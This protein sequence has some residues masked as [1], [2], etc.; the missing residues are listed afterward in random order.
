ME[1]NRPQGVRQTSCTILACKQAMDEKFSKLP[2]GIA[3][4]QLLVFN[5]HDGL[6]ANAPV[7]FHGVMGDLLS[8]KRGT[9]A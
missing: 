2:A 1:V 3:G 5:A 9:F 8:P 4:G 6:M 7:V